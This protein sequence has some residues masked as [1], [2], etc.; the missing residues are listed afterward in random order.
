MRKCSLQSRKNWT[1]TDNADSIFVDFAVAISVDFHSNECWNPFR[2]RR[3]DV[4]FRTAFDPD[5]IK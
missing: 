5:L 4:G 2:R 3:P 1:E